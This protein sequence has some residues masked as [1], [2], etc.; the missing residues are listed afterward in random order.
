MHNRP[1][2]SRIFLES[3]KL[4]QKNN[5]QVELKVF[6]AVSDDESARLCREYD[7]TFTVCENKPLGRKWNEAA[8]MACSY[9]ADYFMI[10]GDDDLY[11]DE[12]F[13]GENMAAM[14]LGV[15]HFGT[16]SVYFYSTEEKRGSLFQYT[17]PRL[18]GAGRFISESAMSRIGLSIKFKWWQP[19]LSAQ[20]PG[21]MPGNVTEFMSLEEAE[22]FQAVNMGI[23][24]HDTEF[25]LWLDDINKGLDG[26]IEG[27][28][29]R[30]GV[31]PVKNK[32]ALPLIVDLKTGKNIWGFDKMKYLGTEVGAEQALSFVHP[33]IVEM[34]NQLNNAK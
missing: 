28:L 26:C 19:Y 17:S 33:E 18:I 27:R 12:Y 13:R 7:V 23:K 2:V 20:L 15:P 5:P 3:L 14:I 34:I 1:E 21:S 24:V 30:S 25:R 10:T 6:A 8:Y 4:N 16:D 11:A 31:M 29:V 9:D 22:Y 32:T